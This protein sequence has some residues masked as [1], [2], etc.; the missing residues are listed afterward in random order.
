MVDLVRLYCVR[1]SAVTYEI[2]VSTAHG[3][4]VNDVVSIGIISSWAN[5]VSASDISGSLRHDWETSGRGT[6]EPV[7][8][9]S[10]VTEDGSEGISG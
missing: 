8:S 2:E 1:S 3:T 9:E 5:W 10:L 6:S 7:R 4:R